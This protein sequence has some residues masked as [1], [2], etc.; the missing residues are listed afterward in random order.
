MVRE[1]ISRGVM[2]GLLPPNQ[3]YLIH[4]YTPKTESS[5]FTPTNASDRNLELWWVVQPLAGTLG[6]SCS[7][8]APTASPKL[9]INTTPSDER[10]DVF[11][12]RDCLPQDRRTPAFV[13]R[14]PRCVHRSRLGWSGLRIEQ[15]SSH[16]TRRDIPEEETNVLLSA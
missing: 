7:A 1:A 11:E 15:R 5:S 14:S 10:L 13:S 3:V 9:P 8:L 16:D 12:L 2:S 4:I 6:D